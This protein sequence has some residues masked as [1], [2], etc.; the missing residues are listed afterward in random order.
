M[1]DLNLKLESCLTHFLFKAILG[2][3]DVCEYEI[4][5]NVLSATD[6]L[7]APLLTLHFVLLCKICQLTS[8]VRISCCKPPIY[9]YFTVYYQ[10][11]QSQEADHP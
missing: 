7:T 11:I 6:L 5:S 2:K 8:L 9:F 10:A 4:D 1:C 3:T